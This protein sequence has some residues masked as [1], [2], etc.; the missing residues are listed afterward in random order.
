MSPLIF[1]D[2]SSNHITVSPQFWVYWVITIPLTLALFVTWYL[3]RNPTKSHELC[4]L[5]RYKFWKRDE[6]ETETD[7]RKPSDKPNEIESQAPIESF[8]VPPRFLQQGFS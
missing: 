7:D 2:D 4:V 3:W 8:S 1:L 5:R 6:N